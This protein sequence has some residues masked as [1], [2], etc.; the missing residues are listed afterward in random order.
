MSEQE[1]QE[2]QKT[3][4]SFIAGLLIGGLLVWV[5]GGTPEEAVAPETQEEGTSEVSVEIDTSEEVA[6][7]ATT[8]AVAEMSELEVGDG[9]VSVADQE[10][11][12]SV[13]LDGA[14]FPTEEG[15]V[16]VRSYSNGQ[17]GSIL[18]AAR[19]SK[20]QGLVPSEV[21]L[22]APT[23]AGRDYA[24]VFFSEDG[25]REF[26]L[27]NDVQIGDVFGTFTAQ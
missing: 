11:G 12:N 26:N 14:T 17:L 13:V 18:G 22:L 6:E 21:P 19:Y 5:F 2:S 4:V 20:E 7:S 25:D 10:A 23:S 1:K 24:V 16:A 27:A 8:E 15:W 3:V 9:D